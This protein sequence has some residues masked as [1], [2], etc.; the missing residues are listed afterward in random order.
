MN[1]TSHLRAVPAQ[2]AVRRSLIIFLAVRIFLSLWAIIALALNPLPAEPDEILR[3]YLGESPVTEGVAGLLL[4][5][6]QRFD[7]LRYLRIAHQGYTVEDSVFPPLYP[8]A[9]RALGDFLTRGLWLVGGNAQSPAV[10]YLLAALI[11]SNLACLG[12]LILVYRIAEAEMDSA[13]ATRT[14][15]YFLLFPTAFFLMGAYTESVFL[16]LVLGSLW[17]ARR[18]HPWLAG[19]L[20]GLASLTRLTG[21][22]LVVPLSY[23]YLRQRDFD[24]RR[25]DWRILASLL[26]PLALASFLGW[27][28][29]IGLPPIGQ[30]FADYWLNRVAWPG[31]D[32]VAAVWYIITGQATFV[33]VFNLVCAGLLILTTP[34]V[35]RRFPTT[36]GLYM[37]SLLLV[38]LMTYVEQRP[39]NA[40]SRYT[41]A[42]FPTFMVLGQL[43]HRPWVN[44]LILYPS[45]VLFLY[46]VGQFFVWGWVA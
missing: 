5:P 41:L 37:I 19:I 39:L 21:W 14:L 15:V 12:S 38:T 13:S 11:I 17:A 18:G 40:L 32:L 1:V 20:G 44:R 25:L 36:Y 28:W 30:V 9:I 2:P 35:W 43:G 45:L 4:G 7:A 29:W 16:C 3:P 33:L 6:W 31:A 27:R 10:G 8:V 22:A 46:F 26:P 23:E 42:F 34:M 24:L